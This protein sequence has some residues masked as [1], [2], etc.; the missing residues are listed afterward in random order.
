MDQFVHELANATDAHG[1][2]RILE[3]TFIRMG[4]E[5]EYLEGMKMVVPGAGELYGVKVPVLRE[6]SKEILRSCKGEKE[7]M[8][9]LAEEC[10]SRGSREH[11]LVAL[12]M[13]ARI[14]LSSEDRWALGVKFLADVNNWESCDQLC[15]ALLGQALADDARYMDILETWLDDESVWVR[16]AALVSPVNLRRSN[17]PPEL[18]EE[19]D[20]R[21]LAMASVLLDDKENYIRKAVDWTVREVIKRHYRMGLEWLMTRARSK[22]STIAKSTLRLSSKKLTPKDQKAFLSILEA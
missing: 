13:L 4:G 15:M 9:K 7:V 19:L 16:R 21:T 14:R 6:L 5:S 12:F 17:F 20:R 3:E 2:V 8:K 22:P 11:Q 1:V 10:W 18:G